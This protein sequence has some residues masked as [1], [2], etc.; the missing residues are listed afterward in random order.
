MLNFYGKSLSNVSFS[1]E[2]LHKLLRKRHVSVGSGLLNGKG[3]LSPSAVRWAV[4]CNSLPYHI[5][6]VV[7]NVMEHGSEKPVAY[8]LR[9]L[10]KH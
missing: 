6:A 8:T 2:T 1:L 10:K 4:S 3:R 5:G 7:A 9:T